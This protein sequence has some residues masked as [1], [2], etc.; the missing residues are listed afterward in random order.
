MQMQ[1]IVQGKIKAFSDTIMNKYTRALSVISACLFLSA[2]GQRGPLV[3]PQPPQENKQQPATNISN[4]STNLTD[5]L[6][7]I[8]QPVY[9]RG[10]N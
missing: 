1:C 9:A 5:N 7:N 10:S 6:G 8:N 2:C 4:D 3:L